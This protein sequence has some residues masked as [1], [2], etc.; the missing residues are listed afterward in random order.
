M[1]HG[2]HAAR[3]T[4]SGIQMTRPYDHTSNSPDRNLTCTVATYCRTR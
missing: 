3:S 2:H 1:P 4:M